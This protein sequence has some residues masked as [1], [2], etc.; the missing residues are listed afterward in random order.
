MKVA[1][2]EGKNIIFYLCTYNPQ[3]GGVSGKEGLELA[4]KDSK[5]PNQ[6]I[7]FVD[8][9]RHYF[10][11]ESMEI[12]ID[13]NKFWSSRIL[14][15]YFYHSM[16]GEDSGALRLKEA[17]ES[18]GLN[19]LNPHTYLDATN[20]P[21]SLLESPDY[22]YGE[23]L[24]DELKSIG[25]EFLV[26]SCG[27]GG[28]ALKQI[29]GVKSMGMTNLIVVPRGHPID[30]SHKFSNENRVGLERIET[31]Y[32]VKTHR[33]ILE[34]A[35][36]RKDVVFK[37]ITPQ[38]I[39]NARDLFAIEISKEHPEFKTCI[40]GSAGFSVLR[41]CE[42]ISHQSYFTTNGM[43]VLGVYE[44]QD[45]FFDYNRFR[46]QKGLLIPYNSKVCIINTG[47]SRKVLESVGK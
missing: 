15:E 47:K 4:S 14:A 11:S 46:N 25:I 41:S 7:S 30:P 36:G 1:E 5:F 45:G 16:R 40:D 24:V 42:E 20:L 3:G 18:R 21:D 33:K 26:G 32:F 37:F 31:P 8:S 34:E 19:P 27:G 43:R 22:R 35:D 28:R 38:E 44:Y 9:E 10:D 13:T 29:R 6:V 2:E 17:L 12:G 39:L 23:G